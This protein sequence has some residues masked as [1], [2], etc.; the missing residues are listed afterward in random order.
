M[1]DSLEEKIYCVLKEILS[2]QGYTHSFG[3]FLN[4]RIPN[5]WQFIPA[6]TAYP[7]SN[8]LFAMTLIFVFLGGI[9]IFIL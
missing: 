1:D 9:W 8:G 6:F 5:Y 3:L 7:D 4:F 2:G